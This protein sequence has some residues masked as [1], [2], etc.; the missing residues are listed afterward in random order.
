VAANCVRT[1]GTDDQAPDPRVRALSTVLSAPRLST[2]TWSR[3]RRAG[4]STSTG[5]PCTP[6]KLNDPTSTSV[7]SEGDNEPGCSRSRGHQG[8]QEGRAYDLGAAH[9]AAVI[10][11]PG[12]RSDAG[13]PYSP[14]SRCGRVPVGVS[15]PPPPQTGRQAPGAP[16][17]AFTRAGQ[18]P[19]WDDREHASRTARGPSGL[20]EVENGSARRNAG[21]GGRQGGRPPF[22]RDWIASGPGSGSPGTAGKKGTIK[23]QRHSWTSPARGY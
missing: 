9:A 18:I 10:R 11:R 17:A 23:S 15:D 14:Y 12:I 19:G 13:N 7:S 16:G 20:R 1:D 2:R 22:N 5:R 6:A 4:H 8:R 3:D 21:R